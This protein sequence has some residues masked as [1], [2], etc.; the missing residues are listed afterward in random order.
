MSIRSDR[1]PGLFVDRDGVLNR[2]IGHLVDPGQLEVLPGVPAALAMVNA[3]GVPVVVVSNQSVVDRGLL[4]PDGLVPIHDELAR[5][6]AAEAARVDAFYT[7][8]HLPAAGCSCRKP[9]PGLLLSS[10][11]E[12]R[13]DLAASVMVGDRPKDLEAARRAGCGLRILVG[14]HDDDRPTD[15]A[16]DLE[17]ATLGE[18]VAAALPFLARSS[19]APY[20]RAG[21]AS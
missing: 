10:A 5:L 3:A 16:A 9:E 7:C 17:V 8:P 20:S 11:A 6:L 19:A 18:A 14:A 2:D 21:G 1:R 15:G 13:L 4:G 12:H